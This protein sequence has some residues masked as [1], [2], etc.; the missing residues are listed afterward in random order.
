MEGDLHLIIG[1]ADTHVISLL[2]M[3]IQENQRSLLLKHTLRSKR[4]N[5]KL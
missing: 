5:K 4:E 3:A 2:K 1:L